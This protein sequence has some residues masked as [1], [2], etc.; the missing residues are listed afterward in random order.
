MKMTVV[1]TVMRSTVVS[2]RLRVIG[3]HTRLCVMNGELT[4]LCVTAW[5]W[6]VS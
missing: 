3:E 2:V 5:D 6:M 1:I 4:R